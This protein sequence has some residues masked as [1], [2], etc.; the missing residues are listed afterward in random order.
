MKEK[1]LFFL[2]A[3]SRLLS[4][5]PIFD[6]FSFFYFCFSLRILD[7]SSDGVSLYIKWALSPRHSQ[8]K[9]SLCIR[10][11]IPPAAC[12]Q[13]N[14]LRLSSL[15]SIDRPPLGRSRCSYYY[16]LM[17]RESTSCIPS[18]VDW[19]DSRGV[20]VA[21]YPVREGERDLY[22]RLLAKDSFLSPGSLFCKL[23]DTIESQSILMKTCSPPPIFFYFLVEVFGLSL[24][25]SP[26]LFSGPLRHFSILLRR[27]LNRGGRVN[28]YG[29]DSINS[30]TAKFLDREEWEI[31]E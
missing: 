24:T 2:F 8:P 19:N 28:I 7:P 9:E 21:I 13:R 17:S 16:S 27:G 31:I 29:R 11:T 15:F 12:V 14:N 26:R 1:I 4:L 5:Y 23:L 30:G 22:E 18:N 20:F 3:Q 25:P 6:L 10:G